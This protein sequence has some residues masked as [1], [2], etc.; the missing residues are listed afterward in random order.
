MHFA[1]DEQQVGLGHACDEGREL[2]LQAV[3]QR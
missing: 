1:G 2:Q 3:I